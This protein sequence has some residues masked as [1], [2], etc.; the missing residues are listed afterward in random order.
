MQSA[1]GTMAARC[2]K[3]ILPFFSVSLVSKTKVFFFSP[4][5]WKIARYSLWVSHSS[6]FTLVWPQWLSPRFY[7][8][9]Q[10]VVGNDVKSVNQSLYHSDSNPLPFVCVCV[11]VCISVQCCAHFFA[12][13]LIPSP[14]SWMPV[15][16]YLTFLPVGIWSALC[17]FGTLWLQPL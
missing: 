13:I 6:I 16:E 11:C 10:C 3:A 9:N 15:N 5:L 14:T 12:Y 17:G 2:S 4:N 8:D 7:S 1:S